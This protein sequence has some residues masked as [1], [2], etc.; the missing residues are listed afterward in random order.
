M[1][2]AQKT[3][4]FARR[5]WWVIVGLAPVLFNAGCSTATGTGALVGTGVGAA[6]GGL[7]GAVAHAPVAGAVIGAAA[8]S[9]IG[10][11]AGSEVDY[12]NHQ[13]AIAADVAARGG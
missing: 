3:Q 10:A 5:G 8:G 9:V 11:S 7:I 13:K 12:N 6:A 4:A 1:Q 2:T